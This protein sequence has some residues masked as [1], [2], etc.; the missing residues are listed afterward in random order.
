MFP[1]VIRK[2]RRLKE[3]SF[4]TEHPAFVQET[5]WEAQRIIHSYFDS[6]ATD[7]TTFSSGLK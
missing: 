1:W 7:S 6:M 3:P 4:Q 2:C 5:E